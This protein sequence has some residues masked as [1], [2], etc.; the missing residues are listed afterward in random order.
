MKMDL[1]YTFLQE[2]VDGIDIFVR[3]I[4]GSVAITALDMDYVDTCPW[5]WITALIALTGLFTTITRDCIPYSFI[6]FSTVRK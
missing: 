4:I 1:K 2:N 3:A 6:G 5:N